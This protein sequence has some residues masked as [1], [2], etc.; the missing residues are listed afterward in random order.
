MKI[1]EYCGNFELSIIQF[2]Y[3][4]TDEVNEKI[5][6]RKLFYKEQIIR[7]IQKCI[8]SFFIQHNL[9]A[10]L[11][12]AYK[13]DVFNTIMFKLKNILKENHIFQCI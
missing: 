10:A 12:Q 5:K 4:L 9:K 1:A 6:K 11:L 7:Y 3:S 8:D 13:N 2:I